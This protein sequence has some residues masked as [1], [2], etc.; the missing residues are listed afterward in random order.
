MGLI[1]TATGGLIV[2]L[3]LWA[4]GVAS[5]FDSIMIGIGMFLLAVA[6]HSVLP[7]LPGRR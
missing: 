6:I 2:W 1:I 3:V 7:Y 5:G 4:I